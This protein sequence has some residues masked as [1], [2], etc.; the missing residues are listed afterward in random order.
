[1][2]LGQLAGDDDAQCGT[3][4]GFEIGQRV[5]DAVRSFVEDERLRRIRAGWA[6]SASRR[7]RRAPAFSGRKPRK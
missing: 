1:M 3:E 5:E 7:V 2:K 4:D 6:A